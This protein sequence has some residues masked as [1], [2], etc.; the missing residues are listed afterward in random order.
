[1]VRENGAYDLDLA[2]KTFFLEGLGCTRRAETSESDNAFKVRIGFEKFKGFLLGQFLIFA[3]GYSFGYKVQIGIL[4]GSIFKSF[5]SPEVVKG[6]LSGFP[7]KSRNH[8]N[9]PCNLTSISQK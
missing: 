5:I 6:E 8:R 3:A 7:Q 1:M 2:V 9:L 4:L